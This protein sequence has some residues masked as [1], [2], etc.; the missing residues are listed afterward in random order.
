MRSACLFTG[1]LAER[2]C[3]RAIS[4]RALELFEQADDPRG[5]A[6]ALHALGR[7]DEFEAALQDAMDRFAE[8]LPEGI[9]WIHAAIGDKQK[10]YEWLAR[11]TA[12][13]PMSRARELE[14]WA[15]REMRDEPEFIALQEAIG[16]S[17]RAAGGAGLPAAVTTRC[18]RSTD[19]QQRYEVDERQ[20][21][22]RERREQA[23]RRCGEGDVSVGSRGRIDCQRRR[24]QAQRGE[25]NS[26]HEFQQPDRR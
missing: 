6:A 11:P 5:K 20:Q 14:A 18:G 15:Y 24:E 2:C 13:N 21:W 7:A 26:H 17:P 1:H 23:E 3:S 25:R 16:V 19:R 9:A 12:L 22:Y 8:G 4:K 10:A